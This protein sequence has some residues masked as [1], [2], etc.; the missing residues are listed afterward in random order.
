MPP[1]IK[2]LQEQYGQTMSEWESL[3]LRCLNRQT[4]ARMKELGRLAIEI[5][6]KIAVISTPME[7]SV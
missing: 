5:Q 1:T 2:E 4:M 3:R 7:S 6:H